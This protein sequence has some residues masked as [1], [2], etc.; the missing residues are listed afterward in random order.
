MNDFDEI[1]DRCLSDLSKGAST[2]DECLLRHPEHAI[3]LRPLLQTALHLERGGSVRPSDAFKAVARTKLT[4]HM[5]AHPRRNMGIQSHFWKYAAVCAALILA[6][7]V[8]GT[9]YAQNSL[10]GDLFYEWKLTSEHAWRTISPDPVRTDIAIANRRIN[11]MNAVADD[12]VRKAQA[13]E[14]YLEVV[15]RLEGELDAEVL[16]QILP[17][18]EPIDAEAPGETNL[19]IQTSEEDAASQTDS[20]LPVST[21]VAPEGSQGLIPTIIAPPLLP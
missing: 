19:P 4:L 20:L 1:L 5:Q 3:Q 8:T 17:I 6:L 18:I 13:L 16:H 12:P 11:E 9:A 14:N 10:P 7:L 2:L 21:E 15:N